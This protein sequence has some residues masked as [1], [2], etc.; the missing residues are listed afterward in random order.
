MKS[1][2]LVGPIQKGQP[3]VSN[4]VASKIQENLK[5]MKSGNFFEVTGVESRR[6]VC[7][8]RANI[9]YFTRRNGMKVAT[10]HKGNKLIITKLKTKSETP[11]TE[12][13]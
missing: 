12:T 13:V 11:K 3:M 5:K 2:I 7:N 4:T 1:K 10:S 9:S 8:L 6:E